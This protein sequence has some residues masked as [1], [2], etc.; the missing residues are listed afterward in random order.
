M[1]VQLGLKF[2]LLIS[3]INNVKFPSITPEKN[4][5]AKYILLTNSGTDYALPFHKEGKR[6]KEEIKDQ[7]KTET[8]QVKL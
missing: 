1:E 6:A 2:A 4:Q 5:K 3:P 8:Y 7:S